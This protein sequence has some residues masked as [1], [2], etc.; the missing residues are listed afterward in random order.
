MCYQCVKARSS[1]GEESVTVCL[2]KKD[3]HQVRLCKLTGI[4]LKFNSLTIVFYFCD[5]KANLVFKYSELSAKV[6]G[7]KFF[8][9]KT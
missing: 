4:C 2:I 5:P 9:L 3:D 8:S 1:Q 6:S 7:L